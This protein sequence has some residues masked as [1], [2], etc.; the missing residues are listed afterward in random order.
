MRDE[1]LEHAFTQDN[2]WYNCD[3]SG[4]DLNPK[5]KKLY[6]GVGQKQVH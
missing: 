6:A 5:V 3:E 2:R 1:N 4:F